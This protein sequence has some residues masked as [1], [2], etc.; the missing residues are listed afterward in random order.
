MA[1]GITCVSPICSGLSLMQWLLHSKKIAETPITQP[2]VFIIGHW[3][4]GTTLLHEYLCLDD[5]F[6]YPTTYQ[7]FAPRHFLVSEWFVPN[8]MKFLVPEKRPMDNMIAGWDKPQ[9]EEFALL[10]MAAP[11]PYWRMAFPNDPPPF[12]ELLDLI[13]VPPVEL[14]RFKNALLYFVKALT[15]RWNKRIMMKSPP[16][17][18]RIGLLA[19]LF[20]GAKFIHIT[21]NPLEIYSSTVKLWQ[22]LDS[23]QALQAPRNE[24]LEEFVFQCFERMYR[25]FDLQ[26][27]SVPAANLVQVRYEDVV[28]SPV[29]EIAKLYDRLD[30]GDF[31]G[32]Q[33][34]LEATIQQN[35]GY[36]RNKHNSLPPILVSEIRRR[37]SGYIERYGYESEFSAAAA[38]GAA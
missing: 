33:P 27:E 11:T 17:T 15:F 24:G 31:T 32:V 18:G 26:L 4:S 10:T 29:P 5:Q 22:S 36:Q 13:D 21:R 28:A 3:R 35:Q 9:E 14:E 16:H 12:M 20:P 37:W 19:K 25:G 6:G 38:A 34:K 30:L 1:L 23:V 2:P 8:Y 7:C